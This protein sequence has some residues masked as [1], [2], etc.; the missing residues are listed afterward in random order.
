[1]RTRTTG[2]MRTR[3]EEWLLRLRQGGAAQPRYGGQQQWP[4]GCHSGACLRGQ[5]GGGDAPQNNR[6]YRWAATTSR[7]AV[8]ARS[9][10]GRGHGWQ[11]RPRLPLGGGVRACIAHS[12]GRKK[13]Y[14]L[15]PFAPLPFSPSCFRRAGGEAAPEQHPVRERLALPRVIAPPLALARAACPC[16]FGFRVLGARRSLVRAF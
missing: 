16:D 10:I 12:I 8:T 9:Q 7:V 11:S 13:A 3:Q 15:R 2:E 1:M 6:V 5:Q 4:C 14:Q